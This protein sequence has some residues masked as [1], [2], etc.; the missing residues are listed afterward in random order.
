MTLESNIG[1]N[2]LGEADP[3]SVWVGTISSAASTAR[4]KQPEPRW[5]T[6]VILALWEAMVAGSL[7]VRSLRQAWPTWGNPVSAKNTKISR[8]WWRMPVAPASWEAETGRSLE[9]G[10][11]GLQR[12]EIAPLHSSLGWSGSRLSSQHLGRPRQVDHL[13]SGA[14][15]QPGQHAVLLCHPGWS[16]V[17]RFQLTATS[18]SRVQ[19]ILLP[20][21]SR[22]AGITGAATTLDNF[23]RDGGRGHH[24]V[25][26]ATQSTGITGMS[27]CTQPKLGDCQQTFH[28]FGDSPSLST[29]QECSSVIIA[30]CSLNSWAPVIFLPQ[31]PKQSLTLSPRMECSGVISAHCYNFHPPGSSHSSASASQVA[32]ITGTRHHAWLIFVFLVETGFHHVGQAGLELLTSSDPPTSASQ[33]A[34][35]RA[36]LALSPKLEC[37]GT[38]SAHC[39]LHLQSSSNSRASASRMA[40]TTGVCHHAWLIFVFL[41]EMGF[42]HVGQAGLELLTSGDPPTSAFQSVGITGVSH[43]TWPK[44]SGRVRQADHLRLG[45]GEQP[46]HRGEILSLLKI[47]KLARLKCSGAISAHCNLCLQGS[48]DSLASASGVAGIPRMCHHARMRFHHD[49]Q[50]G[51]EL[52]T[53]G[54][55]P[56]SASQS[57]R[58]IGMSHLARPK[59]DS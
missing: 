34:G 51:L 23:F 8:A 26:Q 21:A 13:R 14:G 16:A 15:D 44:Q 41:V 43:H 55:P 52:L 47:Q 54:D 57:A 7:E 58:I 24:H 32:G 40:A 45:V 36:G 49:G 1:V 28:F 50:A 4:M 35:I 6:P 25:G 2:R 31:P 38:I 59:K 10:R 20:P 9:P 19:V 33:S 11:Q 30:H 29:R 17:A 22:I 46:D 37:S 3:L 48:S 39:N 42:H 18:T 27:H 5:L 53:S 56:T 12:A